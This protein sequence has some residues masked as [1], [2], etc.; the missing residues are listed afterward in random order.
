MR[1]SDWSSDV[2]SSV[3]SPWLRHREDRQCLLPTPKPTRGS[4]FARR[5]SALNR[6]DFLW[7]H[8]GA[9]SR[10]VPR[11]KSDIGI[12]SGGSKSSRR[13][14]H[15]M[16]NARSEEHTSDLQSLMRLSYAVF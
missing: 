15:Q 4:P 2:C 13:L 10:R 14:V 6:D 1:I 16:Q 11:A 8:F 3:S 12:R 7:D 9:C 5:R